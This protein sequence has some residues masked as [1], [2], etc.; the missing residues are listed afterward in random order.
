VA[1]SYWLLPAAVLLTALDA[2]WAADANWK[3]K[4]PQQWDMNDAKAVLADS[5]WVKYVTPEP[6]RDLSVS[7]RREGG[8]WEAGIGRGVGLDA[9]IGLFGGRGAAEALARAHVKPR[10]PKVMVRWE[11]ALPVRA[12]EQIVGETNAPVLDRDHYAIAVYDIP[13]PNRWNLAGE[14]KGISFLKREKKKNL[15]PSHVEILRHADGTAT[16]VYLFPVSAEITK[17]DG[18]LEFVAQIGR[19]FVTQ[20]FYTGEMQLQGQL[21]L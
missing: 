4:L 15:K 6:L 5:P 20:S 18:R 1:A 10:P 9:L 19:L 21:Q 17:G 16:V 13:T 14:L 8:D 3:D 12:A 7:E 2:S 11:S